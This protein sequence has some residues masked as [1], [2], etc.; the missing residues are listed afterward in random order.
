MLLTWKGSVSHVR[1]AL[2][3][4]MLNVIHSLKKKIH[5]VPPRSKSFPLDQE[6]GGAVCID[7]N[8]HSLCVTLPLPHLLSVLF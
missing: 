2:H 8:K 1:R 4:Q 3:V 7:L 6:P 5:F